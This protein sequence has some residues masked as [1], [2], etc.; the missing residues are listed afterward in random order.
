MNWARRKSPQWEAVLPARSVSPAGM[1]LAPVRGTMTSVASLRP[2]IQDVPA[3][4]QEA[5]FLPHR[6]EYFALMLLR[7]ACALALLSSGCSL[8][9]SADSANENAD[10]GP[11]IDAGLP[12]PIDSGTPRLEVDGQFATCSKPLSGYAKRTQV[13]VD[14]RQ[15]TETLDYPLLVNIPADVFASLQLREG[16]PDLRFTDGFGAL[17]P[18]EIEYLDPSGTTTVWVSVPLGRTTCER[19]IWIYSGHPDAPA[20][21]G[22]RARLTWSDAPAVWHFADEGDI[23]RNSALTNF[24]ALKQ[25]NQASSSITGDGAAGRAQ[26]NNRFAVDDAGSIAIGEESTWEARFRI[27]NEAI[28]NQRPLDYGGLVSL[29]ATRSSANP[30]YQVPAVFAASSGEGG[31]FTVATQ[32]IT[33]GWHYMALTVATEAANSQRVEF[34]MDGQLVPVTDDSNVLPGLDTTLGAAVFRLGLDTGDID[35]VRLSAVARPQSWIELNQRGF[36]GELVQFSETVDTA[37]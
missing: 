16:A 4:V 10:G 5:Q 15:S 2:R 20:Q 26:R 18:Y 6:S 7:S 21:D 13:Y 22:S 14:Y 27:E 34:Y 1:P 12:I 9:F 17:L 29:L 24:D 37:P 11:T 31:V 35:E 19:S 32:P 25:G 36:D 3:P 8:L 28:E 30:D 33:P 23:Q